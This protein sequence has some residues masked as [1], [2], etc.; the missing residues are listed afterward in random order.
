MSTPVGGGD[1][2]PWLKYVTDEMNR[3]FDGLDRKFENMVTVDTFR[4]ERRRVND[5]HAAL[6]KEVSDTATEIKL[7]V[8][9]VASDLDKE[10]QARV[11][12]EA[13]ATRQRQE[14]QAERER[15]RRS[16][17]WQIFGWFA[18]PI[19]AGLVAWLVVQIS[20]LN[21]LAA[22]GAGP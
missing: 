13:L 8:K 4:D 22:G 6:A 19:A 11:T 7:A 10:V 21:A 16:R 20:V 9:D 18:S 15:E 14:D 5:N 12:T 3:R 17:R 1:I 2:P